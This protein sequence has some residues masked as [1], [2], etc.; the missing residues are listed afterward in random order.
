M[1]TVIYTP[2]EKGFLLSS[3]R[4]ES[5]ARNEAIAPAIY[6]LQGKEVLMPVDAAAGG[7]WVAVTNH[8]E[9]LV[10]FNGGFAAH[11]KENSYRVSRGVIVK[12]LIAAADI[13]AAW[14]L[15]DLQNIEPFSLIMISTS[16]CQRVVWD[17]I[18]KHTI[19]FNRNGSYI[20]SSATL[21]TTAARRQRE[22]VFC[23]WMKDR[24]DVSAAQLS[25]FLQSAMT[26]D[27]YNGYIMNRNNVTGTV[28]ISIIEYSKENAIFYYD[29]LQ[30][31]TVDTAAIFFNKTMHNDGNTGT[32]IETAL[33]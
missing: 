33:V 23:N 14:H 4:D 5:F 22:Q 8:G 27:K 32:T 17:G 18:K 26:E 11:Q 10:L 28:S 20:W 7:T 21:Y 24:E 1:C 6:K 29:N 16:V 30:H 31:L 12:Q 15:L 25:L 19:P 13:E 9:A 2:T 3:N